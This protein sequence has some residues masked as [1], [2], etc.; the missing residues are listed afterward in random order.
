MYME[1]RFAVQDMAQGGEGS[2]ELGSIRPPGSNQPS[3][4]DKVR[5]LQATTIPPP[6]PTSVSRHCR[7]N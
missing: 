3:E 5:C 2:R 1:P 7:H 4:L 6:P